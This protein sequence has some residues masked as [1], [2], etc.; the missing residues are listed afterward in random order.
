MWSVSALFLIPVSMNFEVFCSVSPVIL[1]PLVDLR[2]LCRLCLSTC[3]C[4]YSVSALSLAMGVG[5]LRNREF[6]VLQ[7][8]RFSSI[9]MCGF[10]EL[11]C[12]FQLASKNSSK[13]LPQIAKLRCCPCQQRGS[14][15]P[16]GS[17]VF[18]P[19]SSLF[20]PGS[21]VFQPGSSWILS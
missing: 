14:K 15:R 6:A 10:L 19:G 5:N 13:R 4:Q 2:N 21:S 12:E 7:S 16:G 20:Q 1:T 18:Q 3:N 8:C 9:P 17:S 11:S